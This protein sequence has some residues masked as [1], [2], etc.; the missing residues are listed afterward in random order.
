M[1]KLKQEI[2]LFALFVFG[3]FESLTALSQYFG[4]IE[5]N[6]GLFVVTGT[7]G[8][9]GQLGGLLAVCLCAS[10]GLLRIVQQKLLVS[11]LFV[12]CI[13]I[14]VGLILTDSRA[15]WL[16]ALVGIAFVLHKHGCRWTD[17]LADYFRR[18]AMAKIGGVLMLMVVC[19]TSYFYRPASANGRLLIWR[20]SAEMIVDK[21]LLGYG[22]NG[23]SKNYMYYQ[24]GYFEQNP[25][26]QFVQYADN[27]AYPYNEFIHIT[28]AFGAVGLLVVLW[29]LYSV[30]CFKSATKTNDCLRGAFLALLIFSCFSYPLSVLELALLFPVFL[31]SL[32]NK[33]FQDWKNR[34]LKSVL[35]AAFV[36]C[37]GVGIGAI[38]M[39]HRLSKEVKNLFSGNDMQANTAIQYLS[40]HYNR[41]KL[42][43]WLMDIYAQYSFKAY[44]YK[45]ATTVLS[46]AAM[47]TPSS[48]LY[49]DLGDLYNQNGDLDKAEA[50][51]TLAHNM[52]P[53]RL[54]PVYKLFDMFRD[55][56]DTEKVLYWGNRFVDM[57][58]KVEGTKILRM[59]ADVKSYLQKD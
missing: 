27:V 28:V 11:G 9:P 37:G 14:T 41:L 47:I 32:E 8:N 30:F 36:I 19:A 49:C 18:S 44:P 15:A 17:T 21:P 3:L 7:L 16:G 23:F 5:S 50:C 40:V 6:H 10:I 43:P 24:A 34:Y 46:D 58:V 39:E 42:F 55:H 25:D 57:P 52:V 56:Q 12:G 51:Y 59:N 35:L 2:I 4:Y 38:V 45:K 31:V 13:I 54:S 26:S 1:K 53:S 20:V 22:L 33:Y 48:E 29:I